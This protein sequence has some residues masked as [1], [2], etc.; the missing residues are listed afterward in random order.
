MK[1][2]DAALRVPLIVG[3]GRVGRSMAAATRA[4]GFAVELRGRGDR[5]DD[6][7]GKLVLLC[8]PDAAISPLAEQIGAAGRPPALIG[9]TS[10]ATGLD[11]L[12]GAGAAGAFSVHPLQTVPDGETDLR[13]CPA[14]VAGSTPEALEAAGQIAEIA[15]L[16]AFEVA[17]A[18]RAAYHAAASIASNFLVAL[19]QTAAEL[20]AEIEVE[21]PRRVLEPL[22][23]RS[24]D[25]WLSRG[26]E[27]LTGPIAR[28]DEATVDAHRRALGESR[29][30]LLVFYDAL[31]ERTRQIAGRPA[32]EGSAR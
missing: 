20:L 28:G 10:G 21:D 4:A 27:A 2:S 12:T 8:V 17:E 18:D 29:P 13:G 3:P 9:H 5:L 19:E 7:E 26:P 14:A 25:N 30:D 15:G 24:L 23:R 32:I 1:A 31:A 16:E 22:V 6:L 11:A